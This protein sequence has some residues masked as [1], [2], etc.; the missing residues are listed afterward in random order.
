MWQCAFTHRRVQGRRMCVRQTLGC[1]LRDK[2]VLAERPDANRRSRPCEKLF[3]S[4]CHKNLCRLRETWTHLCRCV[5][6]FPELTKENAR[7][8]SWNQRNANGDSRTNLCR[9]L[10]KTKH[11]NPL[12]SE[13]Q[14]L[15][16]NRQEPHSDRIC[17]PW[18]VGCSNITRAGQCFQSRPWKCVRLFTPFPSC[19]LLVLL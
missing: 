1:H 6:T 7:C 11:L 14:I 2:F 15:L 8:G 18:G 12:G 16:S 19:F 10:L 13:C 3:F 17:V 9:R 5:K 4:E